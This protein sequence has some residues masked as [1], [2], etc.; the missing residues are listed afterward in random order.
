METTFQARCR[1]CDY[2]QSDVL[3]GSV[4]GEEDSLLIPH[5]CEC[6]GVVSV[7]VVAT[8]QVCPQCGSNNV[9]RYGEI[10]LWKKTKQRF[11]KEPYCKAEWVSKPLGHAH[12]TWGKYTLTCG[13]HYCPKCRKLEL[14]FMP[15]V[16]ADGK[17]YLNQINANPR[18][19]THAIP[20]ILSEWKVEPSPYDSPVYDQPTCKREK[21]IPSQHPKQV[22]CATPFMDQVFKEEA[23]YDRLVAEELAS[24][25]AVKVLEGRRGK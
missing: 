17:E 12:H 11:H 13:K 23:E 24:D 1:T 10:Q 18:C 6:C 2:K 3:S 9:V 15:Y 16:S 7:N 8:E 22:R 21:L 4:H 20:K 19:A 14:V 5:Y 25:E